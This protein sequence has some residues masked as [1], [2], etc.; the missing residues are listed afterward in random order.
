LRTSFRHG[1]IILSN[2]LLNGAHAGVP[3]LGGP[4]KMGGISMSVVNHHYLDKIII[5]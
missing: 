2:G 1:D 4:S 3:P 5:L